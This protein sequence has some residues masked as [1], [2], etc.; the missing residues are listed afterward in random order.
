MQYLLFLQLIL[1]GERLGI[2]AF[3]LSLSIIICLPWLHRQRSCDTL[4]TP[5]TAV[6][7]KDHNRARQILIRLICGSLQL[8]SF[9]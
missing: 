1:V 7:G 4:T 9:L 5:S 8:L 3:V 6:E 2:A